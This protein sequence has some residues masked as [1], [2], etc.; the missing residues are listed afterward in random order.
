MNMTMESIIEIRSILFLSTNR[1]GTRLRV[2]NIVTLYTAVYFMD[3]RRMHLWTWFRAGT[4]LGRG[5]SLVDRAIA[6]RRERLC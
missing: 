6:R 4:D 1:L 5:R 3:V 2:A